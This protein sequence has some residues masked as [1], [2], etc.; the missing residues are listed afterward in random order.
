[1]INPLA[2]KLEQFTEFDKAERGRL[3]ELLTWPTRSYARGETIIEE[4]EKVG[5]IYLVVTGLAARSKTLRNGDRQIMALLIPGDLCDAEVFVLDKM[6]HDIWA[7]TSTTCTLIPADV[8]EG[9]LTE[10]SKLTRAIWWS[11]MTDSAV[12]REWIV[13]HGSRNAREHIAHLICEMLIRHRIIGEATE[14]AIPF[15]LTQDELSEAT[16]LTSVHVNRTIQQL[17]SEGL[18]EWRKQ[19]LVVLDPEQLLEI[20]QYES[21]YLHLTRTERGDRK[22]SDRA[23]DLV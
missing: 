10:S 13:D 3:D 11:T 6:D 1:M 12:L 9:L 23:G 18:I 5:H 15:P 16:G 22:V 19:V 4:G 8:M 17:R 2:M 21:N 14:N 20:A 7:L